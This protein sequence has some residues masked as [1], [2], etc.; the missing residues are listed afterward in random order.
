MFKSLKDHPIYF[1]TRYNFSAHIGVHK[2]HYFNI[3]LVTD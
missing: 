3:S 1:Q 2:L